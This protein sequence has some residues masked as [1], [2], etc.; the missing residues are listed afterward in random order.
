MF[1]RP[2]HARWLLFLV[3]LTA[4]SALTPR[5]ATDNS[6]AKGAERA[7]PQ[8]RQ[9]SEVALAAAAAEFC[10]AWGP[11]SAFEA[12]RL[13]LDPNFVG[14]YGSSLPA[15]L[16]EK[17]VFTCESRPLLTPASLACCLLVNV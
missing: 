16:Q 7:S 14:D 4:T 3:E 13:A 5:A 17:A 8:L 12:R 11:H 15:I 1:K 10:P 2:R 6:R 9:P